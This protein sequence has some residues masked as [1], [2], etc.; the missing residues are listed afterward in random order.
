MVSGGCGVDTALVGKHGW[1]VSFPA[2]SMLHSYR[3]SQLVAGVGFDP[4]A[5]ASGQLGR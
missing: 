2:G 5:D 3:A 1:S 4:R